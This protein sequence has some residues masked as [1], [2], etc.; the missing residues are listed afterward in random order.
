MPLTLA[1]LERALGEIDSGRAPGIDGI[2][3]E[4]YLELWGFVGPELLN[5]IQE[6]LRSGVMPLSLRRAVVSLLPKSGDLRRMENWRSVSMFCTDYK[7][8][9]KAMANLLKKVIGDL[10]RLDH[11]YFLYSMSF[12]F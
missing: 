3:A 12:H 7:L 11:T 5:V 4:F 10:V 6:S 8:F 9:S 1:E 2:P